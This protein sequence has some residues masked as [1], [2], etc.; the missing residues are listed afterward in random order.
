MP[1][2][3]RRTLILTG[4]ALGTGAATAQEPSGPRGA[5]GLFRQVIKKPTGENGY[6]ELVAACEAMQSS[7]LY[8]RAEELMASAEGL[9][10]ASRRRVLQDPPIVK[11]LSLLQKGLSKPIS[12]PRD[13]VSPDTL[14]PELAAFRGLA[15]LVAMQQYVCLADGRVAEALT[16]TRTC[17]RLG[18]AVQT[19]TLISGL[20]G[21]AITAIGTKSLAGHLDQLAARDCE[22][23]FQISVEWLAQPGLLEDVIQA[24]RR[25]GKQ[26]LAEMKEAGRQRLEKMFGVDQPPLPDFDLPDPSEPIRRRLAEL[27]QARAA[28]GGVDRLFAGIERRMDDYYEQLLSECRKPAWERSRVELSD[29]GGLADGLLSLI[30]PTIWRAVDSYSREEALLRLLACHAAILRYR[31][32]YE[33]L[34]QTLAVLNLGDLAVD[35]FTGQPLKYDLNGR[36]Y[37]LVSAGP[38]AE[39]DD[40]Q[41]VDGRRPVSVLP[42][43]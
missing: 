23:L 3:D 37:R 43:E 8:K 36:R 10:L 6:E 22:R 2:I 28:P 11:A 20:V 13:S 7:R 9:P 30:A 4:L 42:G 17:L 5:P 18:R 25:I 27:E 16:A 33:R 12:S 15:R 1:P 26:T 14:L 32:E 35:P 31:W 41:A 21:I 29:D 24:E 38:R 40:A 34:P 39:P 19:E